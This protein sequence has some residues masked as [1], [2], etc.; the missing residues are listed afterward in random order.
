MAFSFTKNG[1]KEKHQI[2]INVHSTVQFQR[3]RN[4]LKKGEKK[5]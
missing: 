2:E 4:I 1:E 5:T 3:A